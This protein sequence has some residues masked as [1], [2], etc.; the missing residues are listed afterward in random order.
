MKNPIVELSDE[1][2]IEVIENL[3]KAAKRHPVILILLLVWVAYNMTVICHALTVDRDVFVLLLCNVWV[4]IFVLIFKEVIN[5]AKHTCN[6]C[7]PR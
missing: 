6:L 4:L 3:W 1:N 7:S 5:S 2:W